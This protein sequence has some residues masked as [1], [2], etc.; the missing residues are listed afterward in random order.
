MDKCEKK[1]GKAIEKINLEVFNP[2]K[3]FNY[4]P[5]LLV[6]GKEVYRLSAW[7]ELLKVFYFLCNKSSQKAKDLFDLYRDKF[8]AQSDGKLV[9][10][11]YRYNSN[12]LHVNGKCNFTSSVYRSFDGV[13]FREDCYVS[14][15]KTEKGA[16]LLDPF[17]SL[18]SE[19]LY[20]IAKVIKILRLKKIEFFLANTDFPSSQIEKEKNAIVKRLT[21]KSRVERKTEK[22]TKYFIAH[23]NGE[24]LSKEEKFFKRIDSEFNKKPLIGDIVISEEEENYLRSYMSECLRELIKNDLYKK[25]MT[26]PKVFAFGLVRYAMKYYGKK[27]FGRIL[28]QNSVLK[29][30]RVCKEKYTIHTDIS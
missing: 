30:S 26:H 20:L 25:I 29:S 2:E 9:P 16:T 21:D 10:C 7:K 13:K 8:L 22:N 6:Y 4:E 28:K 24:I 14:C 27:T 19:N 5:A 17:K 18:G 3:Y 15:Y 23:I 11:P 12:V 1:V